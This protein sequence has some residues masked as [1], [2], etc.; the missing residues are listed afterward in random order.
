MSTALKQLDGEF[1]AVA[2]SLKVPFWVTLRRV[3][4]P[5]ACRRCWT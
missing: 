2:A 1:E 3:T 5:V 4:L